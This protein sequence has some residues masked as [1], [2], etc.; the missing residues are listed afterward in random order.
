[1]ALADVPRTLFIGQRDFS[2]NASHT[3]SMA[4]ES[5]G[6][7]AEGNVRTQLFPAVQHELPEVADLLREI[8]QHHERFPVPVRMPGLA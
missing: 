8:F 2:P 5:N 1:M 3:E 7:P 6:E 4:G